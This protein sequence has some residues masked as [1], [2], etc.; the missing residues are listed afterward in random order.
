MSLVQVLNL[1]LFSDE[2]GSL[3]ALEENNNIPFAIKRVYYIFGTK[4]GVVRGVHA[5]RNLKQVAICLSGS[6]RFVLDDGIKRE[7]IVLD[8]PTVGLIINDLCWREMHDFSSDCVL[9]VLADQPYD[10]ADYIH[11]YQDFLLLTKQI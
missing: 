11:D 2:Q 7:E 8:C 5:H 4:P 3:V 6:C 1:Q 10:A 9:M